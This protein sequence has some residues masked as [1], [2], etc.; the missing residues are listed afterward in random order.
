MECQSK[1]VIK[2]FAPTITSLPILIDSLAPIT[3]ALKAQLLPIIISA[4]WLCVEMVLRRFNPIKLEMREVLILKLFS[5][6]ITDP[7]NKDTN[8]IP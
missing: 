8:G 1:S 5:M 3:I 2:T 6:F 7:G 4:V